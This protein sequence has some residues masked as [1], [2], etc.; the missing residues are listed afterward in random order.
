MQ[1][2]DYEKQCLSDEGLESIVFIVTNLIQLIFNMIKEPTFQI[3]LKLEQKKMEPFQ[4]AWPLI[5]CCLFLSK[6]KT[7]K[8]KD[9]ICDEVF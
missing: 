7:E 3:A 6:N 2:A 4:N 9:F 8:A 5:A 1:Y